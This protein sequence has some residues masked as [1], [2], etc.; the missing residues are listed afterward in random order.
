MFAL[1]VLFASAQAALLH[2]FAPLYN[3]ALDQRVGK[4]D[5]DVVFA[6][7]GH[8]NSSCELDFEKPG[9][10]WKLRNL[11]LDNS[12][13]VISLGWGKQDIP[14]IERCPFLFA[15]SVARFVAQNGL[16][17]FDIDHEDPPFSS[18]QDF[19]IVSTALRK[20]LPRPLLLTITPASLYSVH[21]PT[22]NTLYDF[23]NA[24]T[25][26]SSAQPFLD[27]GLLAHKL[28]AGVNIESGERFEPAVEQVK[29]LKLAGAFAWTFARNETETIVNMKRALG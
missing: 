18:E 16:A 20:S 17:G 10:R 23:V 4:I 3:D 12:N 25:Y 22:V 28:V 6:A 2:C 5:A 13:V 9:E 19:V 14:M 21:I 8:V 29:L 1:L 26:W 27:A 24:Q 11:V 15:E 7:F